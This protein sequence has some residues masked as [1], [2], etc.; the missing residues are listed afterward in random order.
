M[1]KPVSDGATGGLAGRLRAF[2]REVVSSIPAE[3]TLR[4]LKITE[5]NVLPL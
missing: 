5:E 3:P 2:M 4:V 1:L